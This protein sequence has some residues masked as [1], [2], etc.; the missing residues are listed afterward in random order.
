MKEPVVSEEVPCFE[1]NEVVTCQCKDCQEMKDKPKIYHQPQ[2]ENY[3]QYFPEIVQD[4]IH[5]GVH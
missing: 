2:I 1:D 4:I 5:H 3:F